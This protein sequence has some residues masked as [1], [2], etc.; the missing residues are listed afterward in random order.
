MCILNAERT[1]KRRK[2]NPHVRRRD[3]VHGRVDG[4]QEGRAEGTV[5][6]VEA[7]GQAAGWKE[8]EKVGGNEAREGHA[9][10]HRRHV[11]GLANTILDAI[12]NVQG[13]AYG[14]GKALV[15]MAGQLQ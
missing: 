2:K 15:D 4:A 6:D 8:V 9:R 11:Q 14:L 1:R 7:G 10:M 13:A 12:S 3:C 5:A